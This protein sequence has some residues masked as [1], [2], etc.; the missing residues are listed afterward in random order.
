MAKTFISVIDKNY[1]DKKQTARSVPSYGKN[2]SYS[3]KRKFLFSSKEGER[4]KLF[5]NK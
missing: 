5:N 3:Q 2:R 4:T 1:A